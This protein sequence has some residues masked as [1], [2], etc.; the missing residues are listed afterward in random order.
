[1]FAHRNILLIGF[2]LVLCAA[3]VL[4][5]SRLL[6]PL[7][8]TLLDFQFRLLRKAAPQ[9][10]YSDV[11]VIG[12]DEKTYFTLPEPFALWHPHIGK[13]LSGLAPAKPAVVGFDIVLPVRSYN[14]LIPQYDVSL[15]QGILAMKGAAPLVLGQ[16]LDENRQFRP[17]FPPYVAMAGKDALASVAICL[18][19]DGV[20]RRFAQNLCVEGT[21]TITLAGRM[22]E[23]LG[24]NHRWEGLIDYSIG[25]PFNYVSMLQVLEWIERGD[26]KR[27]SETFS[28]KP[29]LLGAVLPFEDRHRF[30]VPLA[31]WEPERQ[32][33]PGVLIHAQALRSMMTHGMTQP[34][35]MLLLLI[36]SALAAMFWFHKGNRWKAI[37]FVAF[38]PLVFLLTT[39]ALWHSYY[40]PAAS[41]MICAAAGFLSRLLFEGLRHYREKKQM[42]TAFSG[43]VSSQ[44]LREILSG[45]IK[46]GLG[47]ERLK[48]AVL[49][50]DIRGFTTRSQ[51]M[52]PERIIEFLNLYFTEMTAAVQRNGG[53]V[54]KFM[55]DGIMASFG[56]PQPLANAS[57]C[58]LEAAQEMQ[59][60]LY[61]LNIDLVAKGHEPIVIGI[62]I[63]IGDVLAGNIG[64]AARHEYTLIGDVVNIASRLEGLTKEL[65]YPVVCSAAVAADVG[66]AGRLADLGEQPIK[67]HTNIH[68][69]GWRPPLLAEAKPFP[70]LSPAQPFV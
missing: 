50:S 26:K 18:D 34:A 14:F 29:V 52:T 8:N 22:A 38:F 49:F 6:A 24:I 23:H 45:K 64:A 33:L 15:L 47:G 41:L 46:P 54:D 59:Q 27:L 28:G 32:L 3:I 17:I 66:N 53:M 69:Y 51:T 12:I 13:L 67:G 40:I 21:D 56:A 63:H 57:R 30:P 43:Y 65:G 68:V 35:P 4:S 36:L 48:A 37:L 7:D 20:A 42:H 25:A 11:V 62:G 16:S 2:V 55:G 10:L 5:A 9:Q 1:M 39:L 70:A 60:R 61:R 44:V 31:A 58:A 19:D